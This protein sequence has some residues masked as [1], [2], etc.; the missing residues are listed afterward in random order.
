MTKEKIAQVIDFYRDGL[1]FR[2]GYGC[3]PM[4]ADADGLVETA[5]EHEIILPH[6][7]WMCEE[8]ISF[9][10]QDRVDKAFHWLGFIQGTMWAS[11]MRT[12]EDMKRDNM[13]VD[14]AV[15]E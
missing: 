3:Y 8:T 13:P 9:L 10:E 15:A 6:L 2:G 12:I 1:K 4:R 7:L 11:G 14:K 5:D